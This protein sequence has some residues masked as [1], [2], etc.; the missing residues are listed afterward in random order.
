MNTLLL[1]EWITALRSG[2]YKQ[3]TGQL[4]KQ[5]DELNER[6]YCC[7]GVATE[8]IKGPEHFDYSYNRA[9]ALPPAEVDKI[10]LCP[11]PYNPPSLNSIALN[12]A[13]SS[14]ATLNDEKGYSFNQIADVI[15]RAALPDM[16][17]S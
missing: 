2:K 6:S 13:C 15:E 8:L 9:Q 17:H 3:T 10:I 16:R 12:T 1:A 5:D 11:D 4:C 7:L 14:L